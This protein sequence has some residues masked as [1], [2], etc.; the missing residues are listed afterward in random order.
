MIVRLKAL[1]LPFGIILTKQIGTA[2]LKFTESEAEMIVKKWL[3]HR[4]KQ[5]ECVAHSQIIEVRF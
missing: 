1:R 4:R 5:R 3:G 2:S